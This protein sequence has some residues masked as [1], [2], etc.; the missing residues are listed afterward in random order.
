MEPTAT[1]TPTEETD[2]PDEPTC[3]ECDASTRTEWREHAFTYGVGASAREL[4]VTLPVR[5]CNTCGFEFLDH[6]AETLQH[7][8]VCAHLG[9]LSPSGIRRIRER[10]GMTQ[11][12]FAEVTGLGTAT[13]VRWEN[14]SMNQT[15]AYDRYMRLLESP[16]VMRRL[17]GLAEPAAP[18][19]DAPN[20]LDGPWRALKESDS[21]QTL[22]FSPRRAA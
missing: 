16:E 20:I 14:G 1:T 17:R 4:S 9:V 8:A 15:R 3:F 7:E 5:V 18:G 11:S 2:T 19:I 6:E 22:P 21:R 12:E 13:L 10:Y